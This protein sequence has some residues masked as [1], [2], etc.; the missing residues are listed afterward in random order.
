MSSILFVSKP[1]A[2]PWND[3][4]KNLVRD[5]AKNLA[6]HRA[7]V[8][9]RAGEA[10]DLGSAQRVSVY[11][12]SSGGY[13]PALRDQARVLSHLLLARGHAAWH[14]FFAPNPRSNL[15]GR[16]ATRA[17]RMRSIHTLSSAPKDVRAIV[18]QLFADQ[19]IVL[20]RHTEQQLLDAGL[21]SDRL[22]RISPAIEPLT[23][24]TQ[25]NTDQTR[26]RF[27]I[28]RVA[29]TVVYPGD[30]EFGEGAA[31]TIEALRHSSLRDVQLVMACRAKTARAREA[32]QTLR[33]RVLALGLAERVHFVGE[34]PHIHALLACADVVALPSTDLYAKMDYPLVLLEAMSLERPVLVARDTPAA[35]LCEDG[36]ALA[37]E[38][39]AEA[40]AHTLS[41][42]LADATA[43]TTLGTAARDA[44]LQRYTAQAMAARYERVY[45]QLVG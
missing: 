12:A 5:L 30:L 15:A 31:L 6:R 23:R 40:I 37:T 2:P 9:V 34:T 35:E 27:G 13:A 32:E 4:G 10:C 39:T 28:P 16:I 42:L 38:A 7:T 8:M 36:A 22:T 43:R 19:N 21:A 25:P 18:P 24:A 45:D 26:D 29:P 33:A 17:R 44:V 20:S 3:S 11:A 14:F 1:V 41:T